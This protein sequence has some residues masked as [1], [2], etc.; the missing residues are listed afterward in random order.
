[1]DADTT[2]IRGAHHRILTDFRENKTRLLVGTQ[3]VAKGHDF[4]D[5]HTVVVV[6]ADQAFASQT[7]EQVSVPFHYWCRWL[8]RGPGQSTRARHRANLE[9]LSLRSSN[10]RRC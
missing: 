8:A 5:V 2:S 10:S 1:M 9:A 4:P 7:F 3:I 6:S